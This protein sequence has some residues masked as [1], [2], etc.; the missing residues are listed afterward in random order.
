[1]TNTKTTQAPTAAERRDQLAAQLATL[2]DRRAALAAELVETNTLWRAALDAG[3]A[4]EAQAQRRRELENALADIHS[5]AEQLAEWH[6]EAVAQIERDRQ[7]AELDR[8]VAALAAD[9]RR[10]ENLAQLLGDKIG[11]ALEIA[12]AAFTEIMGVRAEAAAVAERVTHAPASIQNQRYAL[13]IAEATASATGGAW[14]GGRFVADP[15][16]AAQVAVIMPG[17]GVSTPNA[18]VTALHRLVGAITSGQPAAAIAEAFGAALG[19]CVA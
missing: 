5:A 16:Q 8:A 18:P 12:Q 14:I 2:A 15:P 19:E 4:G 17:L 11:E 7:L 13:G 6:G 3:Q 9:R 1:M 10:A